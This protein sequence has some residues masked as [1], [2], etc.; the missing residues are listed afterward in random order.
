M[1]P[2][3]TA[4]AVAFCGLTSLALSA[5]ASAT[6]VALPTG[7]M[8]IGDN[9][10]LRESTPPSGGVT[11]SAARPKAVVPG[12]QAWT[13][14]R[15]SP[16]L[17][18]VDQ[19]SAVAYAPNATTIPASAVVTQVHASRRYAGQARVH[20][21]LCW[22]GLQRCVDFTGPSVSTQAFR[23]LDAN[24]PFYLV[25]RVAAWNDSP[26]PLFVQ[27]NVTVWFALPAEQP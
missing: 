10:P 8:Q 17:H 22:D 24:R 4:I 7:A 12:K 18:S 21:S 11:A 13:R 25:H 23:G 27:G 9:P 5:R 6:T 14:A 1:A 19:T 26:K 20:T 16:G 2:R 3:L 15:T